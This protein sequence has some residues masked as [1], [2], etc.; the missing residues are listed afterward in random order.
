[1]RNIFDFFR[2]KPKMQ[3][4]KSSAGD[5]QIVRRPYLFNAISLQMV[6]I[7]GPYE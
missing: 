3:A 5:R 7:D 6:K 2:R 4:L 1:M